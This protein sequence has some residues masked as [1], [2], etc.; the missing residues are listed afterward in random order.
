VNEVPIIYIDI[1]LFVL[2]KQT[3]FPYFL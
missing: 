3:F 1:F 2:E